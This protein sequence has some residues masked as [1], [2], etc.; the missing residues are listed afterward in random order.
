MIFSW[1]EKDCDRY[2]LC[3]KTKRRAEAL[4]EWQLVL[5]PEPGQPQCMF[6]V[7]K[8]NAL[9]TGRDSTGHSTVLYLCLNYIL[10]GTDCQIQNN[11]SMCN[12]IH[13]NTVASGCAAWL[14][15]SA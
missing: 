3:G 13:Y 10:L 9:L 12:L 7:P 11:G 14:A 1:P 15:V 8:G 5:R 6:I 2:I 4:P